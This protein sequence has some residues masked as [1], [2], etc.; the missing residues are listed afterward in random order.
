MTLEIL[1]S[2]DNARSAT[3]SIL[4]RLLCCAG[5]KDRDQRLVEEH[6]ERVGSSDDEDEVGKDGAGPSASDSDPGM[7]ADGLDSD[8]LIGEDSDEDYQRRRARKQ[9]VQVRHCSQAH[10]SCLWCGT[11][12]TTSPVTILCQ[13]AKSCAWQAAGGHR[14]GTG[15]QS[16][17]AGLCR[18]LGL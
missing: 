8:G 1:L 14:R 4:T 5:T 18:G 2:N 15:L 12:I 9:A 7:D 17:Q 10:R 11:I 3:S 16:T 13:T 6:F